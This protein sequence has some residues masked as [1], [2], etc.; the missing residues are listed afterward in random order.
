MSGMKQQDKRKAVTYMVIGLLIFA[1][2]MQMGWL[3]SFGIDPIQL[4]AIQI[5]EADDVFFK[6]QVKESLGAMAAEDIIVNAYGDANAD[7]YL[8]SAT[9]ASGLAT[10]AGFSV[11]EGSSV[12]V[13]G[14][15]AAP[16]TADGYITPLTEFIV[17]MGDPADTV[18]AKTPD[19]SSIL[20]VNNL[21]DSTEPIFA[22]FA[23]DG[24]DLVSGTADNLTAGDL[25]FTMTIRI[26]DDE[27]WYGAPDFTDAV[28]GEEYI[29]GIWVVWKGTKDYDFEQGSARHHL[30][31]STPDNVY[32]AWNYDIR[33]WQDSLQT[34]DVNVATFT[35][36]LSNGADFDK[37]AETL[38][39]DIYDMMLVTGT[40]YALGNFVDGGALDPSAVAAYC[41]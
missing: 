38:S 3:T 31:W 12:W 8:G 9:A 41:D 14:R 40:S 6:I 4:G 39:L 30:T 23:P 5:G 20:F 7:V 11:K 19:G 34:G 17:G 36:T 37:G 21:H 18:S 1:T 28:T 13:Q 27:S 33:L 15:P 25:Y 16:A 10:F 26:N 35:Q 2:S 32:H 22:F 24:A 29:G